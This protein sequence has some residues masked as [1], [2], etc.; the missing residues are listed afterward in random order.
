[1]RARLFSSWFQLLPPA[2]LCQHIDMYNEVI[3]SPLSHLL[4]FAFISF[5]CR[6]PWGAPAMRARLFSSWFQL[7]PPALLCHHIHMYNK[8]M[9]NPFSHL[10]MF[11]FL[12]FP[13][14]ATWGAR[15]AVCLVIPYS[16]CRCLI[17]GCTYYE[18]IGLNHFISPPENLAKVFYSISVLLYRTYIS[19]R[20]YRGCFKNIWAHIA[21][22]KT[23][24]WMGQ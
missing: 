13:C 11:A 3:L 1:M 5:T 17:P 7:L 24:Y 23:L 10:L 12:S 19:Y 9:L 22:S 16:N 18:N 8:V 20:G 15:Q 4:M 14:R 6:A 21:M 2:P